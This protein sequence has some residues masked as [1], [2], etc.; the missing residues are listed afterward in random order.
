MFYTS[1]DVARIAAN[2]ATRL[3]PLLVR[4]GGGRFTAPAQDVAHF[5]ELIEATGRDYVRDVSEPT[6]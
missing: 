1:D 6:R 4:C 2:P 3:K 5:I